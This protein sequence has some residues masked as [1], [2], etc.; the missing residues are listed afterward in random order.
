V[1]IFTG[2]TCNN[3]GKL[4]DF[5][6]KKTQELVSL[7]AYARLR[8]LAPSTVSRQVREGKI[9]LCNGLIDIAAADQGRRDNLTGLRKRKPIIPTEAAVSQIPEAELPAAFSDGVNACALRLA[10]T[11]RATWPRLLAEADF[12]LFQE[13]ARVSAKAY[14][15]AIMLRLT[16]AWVGERIDLRKLPAIDY[17]PFGADAAD[18]QAGVKELLKAWK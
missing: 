13:D 18:V 8:N 10:K 6:S 17:T 5:M 2:A 16:E 12:A 7:R 3:M 15:L 4:I 11:A 14:V 9:P 1:N